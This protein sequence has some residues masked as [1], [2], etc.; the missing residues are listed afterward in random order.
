MN[1]AS[2]GS[3]CLRIEARRRQNSIV[4][5]SYSIADARTVV[6]PSRC[7]RR[8]G[9]GVSAFRADHEEPT[10]SAEKPIGA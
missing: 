1:G 2:C 6:S 3:W 9:G 7:R 4:K 5:M 10:P 8:R